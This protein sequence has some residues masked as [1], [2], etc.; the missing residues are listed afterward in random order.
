MRELGRTGQKLASWGIWKGPE[1]I[2]DAEIVIARD[3]NWCDVPVTLSAG[4]WSIV[5]DAVHGGGPTFV[6]A[7][8][9]PNDWGKEMEDRCRAFCGRARVEAIDLLQ[10]GEFDLERIKA[11]EPFRRMQ[12]VRDAGLAR[13][14]GLYVATLNEALWAIEHAPVVALTIDGPL[15][16][17]EWSELTTAATEMEIGLLATPPAFTY[18]RQAAEAAL[19]RWPITAVGWPI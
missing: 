3:T 18:Q 15:T 14:L 13:R 4:E 1:P 2:R 11:G 5:C 10:L 17:D 16:D 8:L 19:S 7:R 9:A 6:I 12:Q